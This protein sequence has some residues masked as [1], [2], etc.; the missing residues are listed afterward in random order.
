MLL[1]E[2]L[3]PK[4]KQPH[5]SYP[6]WRWLPLIAFGW[7]VSC[8]LPPQGQAGDQ[9][10]GQPR[11]S[12][13]RT[14][15]VVEQIVEGLG[16]V[17]AELEEMTRPNQVQAW[18]DQLIVKAQPGVDMPEVAR[19]RE[20]D[21]ATY[22]HQRTAGKTAFTLRGQR[23]DQPWILVETQAGVMGWVHEGGVRYVTPNFMQW[24]SQ[25]KTSPNARKAAPDVMPASDR[26]IVPGQRVGP[27]RLTT[28]ETELMKLYGPTNVGRS[29][30]K[31]PGKGSLPCT[32]VFPG[33]Q[34]ELRITW[35]DDARTRIAAVYLLNSG[36]T[37]FTPQGL[38]HGL[39]LME[40]TKINQAPVGF[41]GMGWTYA[42]TVSNWKNGRLA[43]MSK[44]F[45]VMLV[46]KD[47]SA[48]QLKPFQGDKV[49]S[50][51]QDGVEALDLYVNHWVV[52]L[53]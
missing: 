27:I 28:D 40:L 1:G 38:R 6:W 45:Y 39:S 35:K 20:G 10:P 30:V 16:A 11:L 51:N 24:L 50:S 17:T 13:E 48:Q 26:V 22:L 41:Y 36:S 25:S 47:A 52:Y 53:D 21:I 37:W 43:P 33:S 19:L 14:G 3:D 34:D 49:F 23:Y 2:F 9:Q 12:P 32:V 31:A 18:V 29:T 8:E 46:A 44:Q 42:G 4:E 15:E 5:R 7:V